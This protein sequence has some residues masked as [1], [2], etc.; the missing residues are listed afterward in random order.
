MGDMLEAVRAK[1]GLSE[2]GCRH[3]DN[4]EDGDTNPPATNAPRREEARRQRVRPRA[5]HRS[6]TVQPP[7]AARHV[8]TTE[9]FA[10]SQRREMNH[11]EAGT[12]IGAC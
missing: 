9:L 8:R 6:Y 4:V 10:Y 3:R 11:R 1:G 7:V 12:H 2:A 5:R